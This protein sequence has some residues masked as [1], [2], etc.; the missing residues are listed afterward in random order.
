[1]MTR[2][3]SDLTSLQ[4]LLHFCWCPVLCSTSS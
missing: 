1:V 2:I 3:S 4:Q